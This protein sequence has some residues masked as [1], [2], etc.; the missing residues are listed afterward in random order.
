LTKV[1]INWR[2]LKAQ[3]GL[4]P[5]SDAVS[6]AL[7]SV[8]TARS[9]W[10]A[11]PSCAGLPLRR[12]ELQQHI[13]EDY[14]WLVDCIHREDKDIYVADFGEQ[15]AYSC[16]NWASGLS[17][18]Y[19]VEDLEWENNSIANAIRPKLARL[20]DLPVHE[21]TGLLEERQTTQRRS[22]SG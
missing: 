8:T 13:E 3:A 7:S 14:E 21:C 6:C 15:G 11:A 10:R 9:G 16:R 19:P 1:R 4:E 5:W 12:L 17:E 22:R 18:I 2:L 20:H